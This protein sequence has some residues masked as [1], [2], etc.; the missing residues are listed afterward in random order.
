MELVLHEPSELLCDDDAGDANKFLSPVNYP[1]LKI[2]AIN[3]IEANN[4]EHFRKTS[5]EFSK[6]NGILDRENIQ[7]H[8]LY[9]TNYSHTFRP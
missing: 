7:N 8:A 3:V 5:G 9:M 4:D 6:T 1:F 2:N